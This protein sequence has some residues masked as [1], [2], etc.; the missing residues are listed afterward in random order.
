MPL[1]PFIIF[2]FINERRGKPGEGSEVGIAESQSIGRAHLIKVGAAQSCPQ[3]GGAGGVAAEELAGE[4]GEGQ[5][6]VVEALRLPVPGRQ[7]GQADQGVQHLQEEPAH[8]GDAGQVQVQRDDSGH[9]HHRRHGEGQGQ[10]LRRGR[11]GR[12]QHRR[13]HRR[14]WPR[15]RAGEVHPQEG[16]QIGGNRTLG[17]DQVPQNQPLAGRWH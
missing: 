7:A 8:P 12:L 16:S 10:V 11:K 1:N 6:G 14:Q 17:I 4:R 13:S 9:Q 3:G 5:V 15:I 2:S